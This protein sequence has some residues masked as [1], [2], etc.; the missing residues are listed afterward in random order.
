[1]GGEGRTSVL[2][3]T[4]HWILLES[5]EGNVTYKLGMREYLCTPEQPMPL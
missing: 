4:L 1:M 2:E 3:K 5:D